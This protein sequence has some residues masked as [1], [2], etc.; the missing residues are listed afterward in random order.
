MK[1]NCPAIMRYRSHLEVAVLGAVLT[2][3]LVGTP[4]PAAAE[5]AAEPIKGKDGWHWH[6]PVLLARNALPV[7][8]ECRPR[9]IIWIGGKACLAWEYR[10]ETGA[11]LVVHRENGPGQWEKVTEHQ[12]KA[13][14][15]ERPLFEFAAGGKL[16]VAG[17][18][19]D[20]RRIVLE[21]LLEPGAQ[22][23]IA[24]RGEGELVLVNA[25]AE[26]DRV[27]LSFIE[28]VPVQAGG[29]APDD[30]VRRT[31]DSLKLLRSADGGRTWSDKVVA[32]GQVQGDAQMDGMILYRDPVAGMGQFGFKDQSELPPRV[33]RKTVLFQ[34]VDQG[35]TWQ[36][37]EFGAHSL[38]WGGP[39]PTMIPPAPIT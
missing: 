7:S 11:S 14:A 29:Q 1:G 2:M 23:M 35:L 12:P 38:P 34:S 4:V 20:G 15:M 22:P 33:G 30:G 5:S 25:L 36:F 21:N 16:Y 3:G 28:S 10:R 13:L 31:S 9:R 27:D 8:G 17:T 32:I 39:F 26:G 19:A 37:R 24:C 18:S 6:R